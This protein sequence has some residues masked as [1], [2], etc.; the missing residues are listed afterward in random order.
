MCVCERVSDGACLVDAAV[1]GARA[2]IVAACMMC[3][4]VYAAYAYEESVYA[5]PCT[6]CAFHS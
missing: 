4:C 1:E 3:V 2:C 5:C 6:M